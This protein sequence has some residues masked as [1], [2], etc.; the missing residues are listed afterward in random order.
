VV[1]GALVRL[2]DRMARSRPRSRARLALAS[3]LVTAAMQALLELWAMADSP[4]LYAS[5]WYARGG[6]RR[7]AQV[8]ATDVLGPHGVI[9]LALLALALFLAGPP[10]RWAQWPPRL[11]RTFGSRKVPASTA[12]AAAA[13]TLGL[14]TPSPT[15]TSTSTPTSGG[16]AT[17]RPNVLILAADSLR[18]DRITQ[19]TAPNLVALA[20]RG[21]TFDRAYVSLPRTFPSWVTLLTGR[22]PH[23]HGIRSMFP[24]WEER[25]KDFDTLPSRMARAGWATA[26]VS[27]YAGDVFGRMDFG[28]QRTMVPEF[29]FRQLV[30]QRA[31]ERMTPLLPLLHS[32]LG[33]R[34]FPVLREMN[35]AADP[36]MVA[37]DA[38]R[39]IERARDDGKPFL[40]TV[41]FSTAHFPYAAPA[42]YYARF[43]KPSYRGRFKYHKPVG[44]GTEAPPDAEDIEQVR[45]LYDGAVVSIDVAVGRVLDA[46]ERAGLADKTILVVTA[47][48][49]ETLYE[50]GHGIGHGDHLFGDE[51]THVPLIVVDPRRRG[52]IVRSEIARDVDLAP[53]LY[54][55][56]DLPV[57]QD[58]DG[59][60]LAGAFADDKAESAVPPAFAF[61]ETGL[62]FTEDISALPS[63]L[64]LPYPG[65]ARL[66][67]VDAAH[68]DEVVLQRAM[69][70]L[71]IT[72]KHR[73]VRDAR[74]KVVYAPTRMGAK[75]MLFDTEHDPGETIDVAQEHPEEV[76]RLKSELIG[77]MLR[78]KDMTL[79]G[80]VLVPRDLS[81]MSE[82]APKDAMRLVGA[83]P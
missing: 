76:A 48:H 72:A 56:V 18:A 43:T 74:W 73:M 44:L 60:S 37:C 10:S 20:A 9:G 13:V 53:T 16:V 70:P 63:S 61:A 68:G 36:M 47:D 77:W 5:E 1:A 41:F 66:T 55:L 59:R 71:V 26:V 57:P 75:Y 40:L 83:A 78:D 6:F 32:R 45:G 34:V 35:D 12:V 42:P 49:G 80:G 27:D 28:F 69:R 67:E 22:H 19:R 2:R 52:G 46:L 15:P 82:A 30:R 31:L 81:P 7:T 62:W 58:L 24:R 50:N 4:Q 14:S 23:H 51:G 79:E 17:D 25:A 11:R 8:L 21:A 54:E 3:L 64:R 29:D 38:A 39:A 33:R 65:I